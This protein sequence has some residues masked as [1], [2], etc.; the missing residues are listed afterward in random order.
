LTPAYAG[1]FYAVPI[2]AVI[3]DI[4]QLV[5]QGA[6]HISFGDPDFLN[7]PTH[8]LRIAR[9]LH[10]AYPDVSFSYTAKVEH[11]LKHWGAVEEMHALGC[12]FVVSAAESFNDRTLEI[13]DKGHTRG[14][15]IEAFRR[16]SR[17]GLTLRPS[18][19]PFTPWDSLDDFIELLSIVARE[20]LVDNVDAVQYAIRLLL[21]LGSPLL[22][23]PAMKAHLTAFDAE[24]FTY[25]WRHP[26][27]RMDELQERI[28]GAVEHAVESGESATDIFS[29][30]QNLAHE[31]AG[32]TAPPMATQA[33]PHNPPRMTESWF[34]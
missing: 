21:P 9:R 18:F 13:L 8:A 23:E 30:V 15:A 33:R 17:I 10:D 12:L 11:V 29:R 19:V 6:E 25:E 4:S 3:A 22:D 32:R 20:D 31:A 24:R 5:D 28:H 27:P 1:R 34:C 2:D 16:F 14:D 26:D 7:G